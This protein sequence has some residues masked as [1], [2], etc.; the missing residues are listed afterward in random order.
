VIFRPSYAP[1]E[2]YPARTRSLLSASLPC[3]GPFFV[4]ARSTVCVRLA[5]TNR[6][7]HW[8]PSAL[9]SWAAFLLTE[10]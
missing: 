3:H 1:E 8:S 6:L 5:D 2:T 10:R 4:D 7:T 9:P